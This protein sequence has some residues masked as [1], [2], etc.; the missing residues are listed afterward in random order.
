MR[1]TVLCL[2][3]Q[4]AFPPNKKESSIKLLLR[5]THTHTHTQTHMITFF[6][7]EIRTYLK[8]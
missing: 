5:V 6:D 1:S 2:S 3:P 4:I 7:I 8:I